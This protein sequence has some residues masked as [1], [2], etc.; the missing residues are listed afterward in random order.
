MKGQCFCGS[1]RYELTKEVEDA[2]YCHCRDC[3][4]LSGSAFHVLGIVPRGSVNILCGELCMYEHQA[5]SGFVMTRE[6]CCKCGTPLF[7]SSTRFKQIQMFMLS[8]LEN[9]I[10]I[11]PKFEIWCD[12]KVSWFK[13]TD[14]INSFPKGES[15]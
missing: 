2:Y 9:P 7:A 14:E 3:Q 8:T 15:E 10:A 13:I 5:A 1:I 11:Q 4:I 6:F 12:S